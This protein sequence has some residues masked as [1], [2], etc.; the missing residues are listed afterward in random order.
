VDPLTTQEEDAGSTAQAD[1]APDA[2]VQVDAETF[3]DAE[4]SNDATTHA[5]ANEPNDAGIVVTG[6]PFAIQ[7]DTSEGLTNTGT[8]LSAILEN[9]ALEDACARYE[10]N[11]GDRRLKLLCGKYLF[12]Y[13]T[14]DTAGVP[15]AI[16]DFLI[17][18]FP[19]QIGPGFEK[20]GMIPDPNSA[21]MLPL[22]LAPSVPITGTDIE[23]YAFT[24]ASCHFGRM[25][26]GRYAV[27]APN[28]EYEYGRM[29]LS[30]A[31][32]PLLAAQSGSAGE[33]DPDAVAA[34]QPM[35]DHLSA[36]PGLRTRLLLALLPLAG[37][38]MAPVFP[39]ETERHYAHWKSGTMDFLIEPLPANDRVHTISKISPLFGIPNRSETTHAYLGWTGSTRSVE[40]FVDGFV[41][42]GGGDP[43]AWPREK[44]LPLA[45]YIYS[46]RAPLPPN[47]LDV[48]A[49]RALFESTG[50]L[51]CHSGPRGAGTE[52]YSY[53]EIGTDRALEA[54]G[55]DGSGMPCCNLGAEPLTRKLKSPRLVSLWAQSRFLHNGSVDSLEDLFCAGTIVRP[56]TST[57]AYGDQGHEYGCELSANEKRDLLLFLR[58][59]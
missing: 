45:D 57:I 7:P 16:V 52:L 22:G 31:V 24:C 47:N 33:H 21:E 54:W 5:D 25:T 39:R 53:D 37:N 1:A 27:G 13:G 8:D 30:I 23:T 34:V 40:D 6:D 17:P 36:T 15:R 3:L 56:T 11:P 41:L 9:G 18:N 51:D 38:A 32:F 35:L 10:T 59:N 2:M 20:L 48:T 58:A 43:S 49:G 26:D 42:V 46:L 12:F 14:F 44:L 55:D 50:C 29:N 28:H 4:G 19:N